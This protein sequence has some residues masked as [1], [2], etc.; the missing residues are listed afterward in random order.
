MILLNYKKLGAQLHSNTMSQ[1]QYFSYF[2]VY[3]ALLVAVN[4]LST[5]LSV[6]TGYILSTL[7]YTASLIEIA[8]VL[9]IM[10]LLFNTNRKGDNDRFIERYICLSIPATF[11]GI[12]L[13]FL[14]YIPSALLPDD[15][16]QMIYG[17]SNT[18][19]TTPA[20]LAIIVILTLY[21]YYIMHRGFIIASGQSIPHQEHAN[22]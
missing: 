21:I 17:A 6:E 9:V 15:T 8:L 10:V 5:L 20:D 13:T 16:S 22:G 3:M 18:V 4:E 12:L 11:R 2:F 1:R 19:S 7:D 14:L